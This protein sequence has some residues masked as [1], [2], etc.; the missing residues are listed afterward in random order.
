MNLLHTSLLSA[1]VALSAAALPAAEYQIDPTH[2]FARFK[3]S[4]LGVGY[5]VGGFNTLSGSF[6][7]DP[8]AGAEAQSI[9]VSVDTESVDTNMAE[10]DKHVRSGDYLGVDAHPT[11][12]FTST[13][14]EGDATGGVMTGDLTFF[15]TTKP[16]EIAVAMIGE[17]KDPWGGYRAGFEGT[18]TLTPAE[19]GMEY[20]L[21]PAAE[22]VD[23]TIIVEGV[24]Q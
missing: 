23:L 13:G 2:T 17:G 21:G 5:V 10:R 14:F 11:A 4:H 16:V 20:N 6:T 3:I 7:Y 8:E 1:A 24:R 18:L 9:T 22:T 12:T 19:F 15:G